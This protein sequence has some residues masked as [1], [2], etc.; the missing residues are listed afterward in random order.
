MNYFEKWNLTEEEWDLL[1]LL[2]Y[3]V[4]YSVADADGIINPEEIGPYK[5]FRELMSTNNEDC[6]IVDM[7]KTSLDRYERSIREGDLLNQYLNKKNLIDEEGLYIK[8][9]LVVDHF[10][11]VLNLLDDYNKDKIKEYLFN[12]GIDTAYS[13]GVPENPLDESEAQALKEIFRWLEIDQDKFFEQSK[14]DA[15]YANLNGEI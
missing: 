4:S 3:H 9:N 1:T 2:P 12:L 11:R 13:Y 6:A 15:F 10:L 8:K 14:R 7:C 5:V